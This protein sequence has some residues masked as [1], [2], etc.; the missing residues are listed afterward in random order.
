MPKDWNRTDEDPEVEGGLWAKH[1][2]KQECMKV[3]LS[4]IAK[5]P[6]Q[7]IA[8]ELGISRKTLRKYFGYEMKEAK[9]ILNSSVTGAMYKNA[10]NGHFPAQKWWSQIIMGWKEE[11]TVEHRHY[12]PKL[13]IK[14]PEGIDHSKPMFTLDHLNDSSTEPGDTGG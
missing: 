7:V 2:T 14:P 5:V 1:F 3:V 9:H 13:E 10:M 8:T 4:K 6:D 11:T 12:V